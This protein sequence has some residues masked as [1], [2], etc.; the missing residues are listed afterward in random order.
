MYTYIIRALNE[1]QDAITD[2]RFAKRKAKDLKQTQVL[3][4]IENI[5][6]NVYAGTKIEFFMGEN[7][8]DKKT[9][10]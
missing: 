4:N 3:C 8:N 7:K 1:I 10:I 5:L 9:T 2:I 6:L